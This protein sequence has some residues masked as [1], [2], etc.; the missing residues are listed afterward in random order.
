MFRSAFVPKPR[1]LDGR[2]TASAGYVMAQKKGASLGE[3]TLDDDRI[4]HGKGTHRECGIDS[5]SETPLLE[6][7]LEGWEEALKLWLRSKI[8]HIISLIQLRHSLRVPSRKNGSTRNSGLQSR[9]FSSIDLKPPERI[10]NPKLH[11]FLSIQSTFTPHLTAPIRV[12]GA[13]HYAKSYAAT[14]P[15]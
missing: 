7:S 11:S 4:R 1:A 12:L 10:Q 13:A 15:P 5:N 9:S 8:L 14:P 6:V 3:N 2:S